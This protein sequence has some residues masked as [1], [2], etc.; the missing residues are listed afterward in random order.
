MGP[1]VPVSAPPGTVQREPTPGMKQAPALGFVRRQEN[2]AEEK[3]KG[4][5]LIEE[6]E[7]QTLNSSSRTEPSRKGPVLNPL[8]NASRCRSGR[9]WVFFVKN[10]PFNALNLFFL[11]SV[12][13]HS[14]FPISSIPAATK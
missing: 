11:G 1:D 9:P 3:M 7:R 10:Y 5:L 2:P 4:L 12:L 13:R 6:T 14:E 8:I